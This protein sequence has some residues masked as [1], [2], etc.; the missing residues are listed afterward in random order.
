[1]RYIIALLLYAFTCSAMALSRRAPTPGQLEQVTDFGDN[2]SNVGFYIYVPE[3]LASNPAIIV[4]IHYCM[5]LVTSRNRALLTRLQAQ[6]LL[7]RT[8][9]AAHMHNMQ[10]ST[11]LSSSTQKAH[12]KVDAGMSALSHH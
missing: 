11:A 1:M 5:R 8:I 10:R 12:T 2:A 3:N 9:M 7:K 4:A 6:E